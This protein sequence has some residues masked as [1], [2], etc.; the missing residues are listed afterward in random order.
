[1]ITLVVAGL[2][3]LARGRSVPAHTRFARFP[4][5][6]RAH[7]VKTDRTG[8]HVRTRK[9]RRDAHQQGNAQQ[10]KQLSNNTH[11]VT[12]RPMELGRG[13]AV[14]LTGPLKSRSG[15]VGL[16]PHAPPTERGRRPLLLRG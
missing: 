2:S 16:T 5:R 12:P 13:R 6:E 3:I 10:K 15:R 8:L 14:L 4:K 9:V 11:N 1:M 7:S